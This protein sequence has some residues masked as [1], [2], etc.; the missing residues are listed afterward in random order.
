MV[1]EATL[2]SMSLIR[3]SIRRSTDFIPSTPLLASDVETQTTID[4][5]FNL[6]V[7]APKTPLICSTNYCVLV[8]SDLEP[9][10]GSLFMG[11]L[12]QK[13]CVSLNYVECLFCRSSCI[14]ISNALL[15]VFITSTTPLA[16]LHAFSSHLADTIAVSSPCYDTTGFNT[17]NL[18]AWGCYSP[19]HQDWLSSANQHDRRNP[20]LRPHSRNDTMDKLRQQV[21]YPGV[22]LRI[23]SAVIL[24]VSMTFLVLIVLSTACATTFLVRPVYNFTNTGYHGSNMDQQRR[25]YLWN[26]PC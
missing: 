21:R 20:H 1:M 5:P 24:Y 25:L 26:L 23:I 14:H 7:K 17:S 13:S 15:L 3:R 19:R 6:L 2:C 16:L 11:L 8:H 18:R 4:F 10:G 12:V 22:L 9:C